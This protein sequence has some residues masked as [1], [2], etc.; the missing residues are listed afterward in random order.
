MQHATSVD[1]VQSSLDHAHVALVYESL[2]L[3]GSRWVR[4]NPDAAYTAGIAAGLPDNDANAPLP[5]DI[6][7]WLVPE[8]SSND[9][10]IV[11]AGLYELTDRTR[12]G[13]WAANLRSTLR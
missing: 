1:H 7:S 2:R 6:T 9:T 5:S 3:G 11:Q 13:R 8:S 10:K 4:I 12:F